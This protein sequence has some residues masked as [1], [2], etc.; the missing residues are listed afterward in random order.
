MLAP[1]IPSAA[2]KPPAQQNDSQGRKNSP[3]GRPVELPERRTPSSR[4]LKNPDGSF[5]TGVY[6][7][8]IYFRDPSGQMRPVQNTLVADAGASV[9]R[10]AANR[11]QATFKDQ[12]SNTGR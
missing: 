2:A 11:Y 3:A 10:N 12:G 9:I 6:N 7:K 4:T 5:T 1:A 8:A